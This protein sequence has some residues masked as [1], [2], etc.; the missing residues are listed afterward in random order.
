MEK[1]TGMT[2]A[3]H[4]IYA[5]YRGDDFIFMG[6]Q[7]ECAEFLDVKPEFIHWLTTPTGKKRFESRKDQSKA[8]TAV[9]VDFERG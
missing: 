2:Y 6:K 4:A 7:K 1:P 9:V 8:L 3:K 5:L